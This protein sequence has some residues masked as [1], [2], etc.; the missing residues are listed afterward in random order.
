VASARTTRVLATCLALAGSAQAQIPPPEAKTDSVQT[1]AIRRIDAQIDRALADPSYGGFDIP[2][3]RALGTLIVNALLILDTGQCADRSA[4]GAAAETFLFIGRKML[5][6]LLGLPT[7]RKAELVDKAVELASE[8]TGD[9]ALTDSLCHG[10]LLPASSVQPLAQRQA[11]AR[12]VL[13]LGLSPPT[14]N[15]SSPPSNSSPPAA[16][17]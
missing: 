12:Q 17:P 9:A 13:L 3:K 4:P 10:K 5:P 6:P 14:S 8:Q 11:A 16:R 1:D 2:Q 7:S 15:P